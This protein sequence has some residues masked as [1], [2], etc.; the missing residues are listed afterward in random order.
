MASRRKQFTCEYCGQPFWRKQNKN[1]SGHRDTRR[2]CSRRCAGLSR[3]KGKR[4]RT[5]YYAWRRD[6]LRR[7]KVCQECGSD[8]ELHAHHIKPWQDFP[9]LRY[10]VDN[11][12]LLCWTCHKKQ[13]P[14]RGVGRRIGKGLAFCRICG[15]EIGPFTKTGCCPM[16][17]ARW[18]RQEA[19]RAGSASGAS[20]P[21]PGGRGS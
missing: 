15:V 14:A 2:F 16:H 4:K 7:D 10:V 8:T 6:V 19:A 21:P 11:G 5:G 1:R 20:S 17:A 9:E 12:I 18:W 3:F 13:H